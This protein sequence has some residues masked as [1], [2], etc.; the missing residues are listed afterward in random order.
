M[1]WCP[2]VLEDRLERQQVLGAVVDDED[3]ELRLLGAAAE[4]SFQ[5]VAPGRRFSH[6]CSHA[7]SML[8][9]CWGSTGFAM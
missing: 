5:L 4:P 9:S 1:T 7:S 8:T 2:S 6:R 3:V